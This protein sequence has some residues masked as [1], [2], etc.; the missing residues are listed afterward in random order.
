MT[1]RE[2][3]LVIGVAVI[4]ALGLGYNF[5]FG[6]FAPQPDS[7]P[8][9]L[10]SVAPGDYESAVRILRDE[11]N[12]TDRNTKV[13]AKLKI[14]QTMFGSKAK[15]DEA[16]I[17]LLQETEKIAANSNLVI[18]QKNIVRFSETLIG[19][20]LEGKTNPESLLRFIQRTTESRIGIKVN[21]LQLHAIPNQKLLNYQIVVC[22]MLL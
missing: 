3:N 17:R 9:N 11:R 16:S 14:L 2:R 1:V 6:F 22:S 5:L 19:V 21:R 8:A 10:G 18:E 7:I 20:A 12:I 15:A 4:I 13:A